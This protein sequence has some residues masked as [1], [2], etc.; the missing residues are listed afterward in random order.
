MEVI[1]NNQSNQS[2]Q[3]TQRST[4]GIKQPKSHHI[5][6]LNNITKEEEMKIINNNINNNINSRPQF[7]GKV[8]YSGGKGPMKGSNAISEHNDPFENEKENLR[9]EYHKL[10]TTIFPEY[11]YLN[12]ELNNYLG[13]GIQVRIIIMYYYI[14][15]CLHSLF[16]L[17]VTY[18]VYVIYNL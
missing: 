2:N 16:C 11:K 3:N 10:K 12:E 13:I 18:I 7:G 14:L 17:Y 8:L 4:I 5:T 15:Y 9:L 1:S 6:N